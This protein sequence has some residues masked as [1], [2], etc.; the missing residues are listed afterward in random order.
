M[1]A[2]PTYAVQPLSVVVAA[3]FQKIADASLHGEPVT[4]KPRDAAQVR[5]SLTPKPCA[6]ANAGTRTSARPAARRESDGRGS[7]DFR[8]D[9]I[10]RLVRDKETEAFGASVL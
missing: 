6:P 2:D 10:W 4:A 9:C 3:G 8:E 1:N 5:I 7:S